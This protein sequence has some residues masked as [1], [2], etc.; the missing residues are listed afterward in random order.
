[1]NRQLAVPVGLTVTL[2]ICAAPV[3]AQV[4]ELHPN[5][6]YPEGSELASPMTGLSFRLPAGFRAEWDAGMGGLLALENAGQGFAAVWGWSEGTVEEAAG[7]MGARLAQQ[8]IT[9]EARDEPSVTSDGFRGVFDA[10]ASGI[11]GVLHAFVRVGPAGGVIA[12]AG[13]APASSEASA[14]AFVDGIESSL[15]WSEPLAARWRREI[16]GVVFRREGAGPEGT[17]ALC[18]TEYRYS[19][20]P[21]APPP[22][23]TA[24]STEEQ[25]GLWWLIADLAG[26]AMLSLETTD[27][28]SFRGTFEESGT[29]YLID[30]VRY[31]PAGAC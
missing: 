9:L 16:T 25:L 19:G 21:L 4:R 26:S 27:G 20:S 10:V 28:R 17:L 24:P 7:E 18:A 23:G 3:L 12:V 15:E 30:G 13:L 14:A 1:M 2:L 29:R 5:G 22:S 8:G 11:R 6:L 31:R